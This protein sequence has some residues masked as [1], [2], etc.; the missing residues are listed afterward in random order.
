MA[1]AYAVIPRPSVYDRAA[2]AEIIQEAIDQGNAIIDAAQQQGQAILAEAHSLADEQIEAI[3]AGLRADVEREVRARLASEM[4]QTFARFQEV[5]AG[6]RFAADGLR[7]AAYA[8]SLAL[9]LGVAEHIIGREL[10]TEPEFVARMLER[11][12]EQVAIDRVTRIIVHPNDLAIV[13]HWSKVA[14]GPQRAE[15]EIQTDLTIEPGG[16]VIGT[17]TGFIDGRIQ[18]QLAE[19]RRALAEVVEDV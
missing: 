1:D 4:D 11:M 2:A 6:S 15:I 19:V 7:N 8:D 18:T 16:C 13:D 12:L 17:R 5:I 9:A 10:T 14:L 3:R